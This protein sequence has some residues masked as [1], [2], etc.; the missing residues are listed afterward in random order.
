MRK[1]VRV[2]IDQKTWVGRPVPPAL[3]SPATTWPFS[4]LDAFLLLALITRVPTTRGVSIHDTWAWSRYFPAL[5]DHPSLAL[6]DATRHLDPHQKSIL[7]DDWGMAIPMLFLK[8]VLN[9]TSICPTTFFLKMLPALGLAGPSVTPK[10]GTK[11]SPDFV[12]RDARGLIH[13]VESKGT[14]SSR[15]ALAKAMKVGFIQKSSLTV[16]ASQRGERLVAGLYIARHPKHN[17]VVAIIDPPGVSTQLP[18]LSKESLDDIFRF[19]DLSQAF[20]LVGLHSVAR[21][22]ADFAE[23][24]PSVFSDRGEAFDRERDALVDFDGDRKGFKQVLEFPVQVEAKGLRF[25]SVQITASLPRTHVDTI[26]KAAR[27]RNELLSAVRSLPFTT[28]SIRISSDDKV[29]Y[30]VASSGLEVELNVL[31]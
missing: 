28:Q 2:E 16:A 13:I 14:Q 31:D 6:A 24:E 19:S 3:S 5:A 10:T 26:A 9:F 18:E 30:L 25:S 29:G 23:K 7:S 27:Q 22:V 21:S 12:A 15:A 11:K 4:V 1:S 20:D 17:S 8:E